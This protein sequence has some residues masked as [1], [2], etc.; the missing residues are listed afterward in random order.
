MDGPVGPDR[1]AG[2][3]TG[4]RTAGAPVVRTRRRAL[5]ATAQGT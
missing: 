2:R 1:P 5:T 3:L 4:S